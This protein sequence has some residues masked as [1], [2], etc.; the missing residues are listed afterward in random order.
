MRKKIGLAC[1]ASV[2]LVSCSGEERTQDTLQIA[3]WDED[4]DDAVTAAIASFNEIHPDIDV[5]VTYTPFAQYW[6]NLSTSM[7]AGSGPDLFWMNAV[8][9]HRYADSGLIKDLDPFVEA[10]AEY[11]KEDYYENAVELY[12]YEDSLYAAPYFVDAIALVY[13]KEM[14]DEA[15]VDY[16][17]ETWTWDDLEEAGAALTD[18]EA[19]VYGYGA[20]ITSN[21]RG[22]YNLIHQAG[23]QIVS[24]DGLYS[25]FGTEAA[26]EALQFSEH[27]I[28]EGI[29]PGVRM[30]IE[31]AMT[32]LFQSEMVAMYPELSPMLGE[33]V[34][35]LGDKVEV[36][37]LPSH[38]EDASI[39]HGIGWAMN[40]DVV[41]PDVVWDLLRE[42]T[43]E[44][45]NAEIAD[46]GFSTPAMISQGERWLE[47]TPSVNLEVFLEAQETG[48][49]YP[50][51]NNTAEWQRVE[52]TEIQGAFLGQKTI[53]EA[54]ETVANEMDQILQEGIDVEE[55][56]DE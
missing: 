22:Y 45:G 13:N 8:N 53:E 29:S 15:G 42:L 1:A 48:A 54:L 41:D 16:P 26:L 44:T 51:S 5:Q 50:V 14:F 36:A 11:D 6:T 32:Q 20:T 10:D 3:L 47:S 28:E 31:S 55:E 52:Q 46:S 17:D 43:S 56:G 7:G 38:K 19:G 25:G 27:L 12:S 9:F 24:D 40:E 21:Q 49:P 34:E 18:E 33:V 39:I 2:L 23:G 35:T 4:A 37:P 30:Q